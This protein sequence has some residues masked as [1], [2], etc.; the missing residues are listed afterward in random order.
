MIRASGKPPGHSEGT[1]HALNGGPDHELSDGGQ[2]AS[3]LCS[4]MIAIGHIET[5]APSDETDRARRTT[6]P[7]DAYE[8]RTRPRNRAVPHRRVS[9]DDVEEESSLPGGPGLEDCHENRSG[10]ALREEYPALKLSAPGS[11]GSGVSMRGGNSA[12]PAVTLPRA[13]P[14]RPASGLGRRTPLD[15]P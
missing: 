10:H 14:A 15:P 12:C 11:Q 9:G 8:R 2:T 4:T 5:V 13:K 6:H 3:K 1:F 7:P